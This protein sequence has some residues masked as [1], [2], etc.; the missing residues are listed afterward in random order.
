MALPLLALLL[1]FPSAASP[2][3]KA[4]PPEE[5]GLH[6]SLSRI[7]TLECLIGASSPGR[8][9]VTL[10]QVDTFEDGT[11]RKSVV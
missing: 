10:G 11:D 9:A 8:A 1:F 4:T 7:V 5:H 2:G 3:M 6:R